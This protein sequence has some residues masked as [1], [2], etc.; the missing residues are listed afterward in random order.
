MVQH[1]SSSRLKI[2]NLIIADFLKSGIL[3]YLLGMFHTMK[4]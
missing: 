1:I 4:R 3:E 2:P